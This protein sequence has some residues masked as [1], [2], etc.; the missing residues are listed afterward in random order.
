MKPKKPTLIEF[1][2]EM[3]KKGKGYKMIFPINFEYGETTKI[4]VEGNWRRIK[5]IVIIAKANNVGWTSKK[6]KV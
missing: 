2:L 5:K 6:E 1:D 3:P 4:I